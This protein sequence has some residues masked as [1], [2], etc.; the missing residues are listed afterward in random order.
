MPNLGT[1]AGPLINQGGQIATNSKDAVN[2]ENS[3]MYGTFS[4]ADIKVSVH[5]PIDADRLNTIQAKREYLIEQLNSFSANSSQR[6]SVES[7]LADVQ[8][9]IDHF[10]TLPPTKTLA[11]IQTISISSFREK[12]PFRSF[13]STYP[14]AI[15]RGTRSIAGSIIFTVFHQ[16]VFHEVMKLV[17]FNNTGTFDRD[18]F[19]YTTVLADQMPPLDLT[20]TFANEYGAISQM[21]LYGVDFFQEGQTFSI[22]DIYSENVVQYIARDYDPLRGIQQA[23]LEKGNNEE[24]LWLVSASDLSRDS[25]NREYIARRNPFI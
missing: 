24:T 23:R 8:D 19:S 16:H 1:G 12:V 13:G 11:E 25:E 6:K 2:A 9:Q 18:I 22:E 3:Y 7:Q 5:L 15:T 14:R 17:Q 4:G 10:T 20:L 21:G